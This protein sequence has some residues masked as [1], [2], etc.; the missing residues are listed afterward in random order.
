MSLGQPDMA[1]P[2]P[3]QAAQYMRDLF[4][5]M[6]EPYAE[7]A[8]LSVL[9]GRKVAGRLV[10]AGRTVDNA[11][12]FARSSLVGQLGTITWRPSREGAS[13][14]VWGWTLHGL[15]TG[16][17]PRHG[18]RPT[19]LE[20]DQ[21]MAAAL[22]S[23]GWACMLTPVEF[24]EKWEG[25]D[26]VEQ[27]I[28]HCA[29]HLHHRVWLVV[30]SAETH[31]AACVRL[32]QTA[33]ARRRTSGAYE[34]PNNEGQPCFLHILNASAPVEQFARGTFHLAIVDCMP[35][36]RVVAEIQARSRVVPGEL[37]WL[38]GEPSWLDEPFPTSGSFR[39]T[40]RGAG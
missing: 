14:K 37:R 38:A 15:A 12:Y 4:E 19:L 30:G 36:A 16:S 22:Q 29:T 27:A 3:E 7:M 17:V 23:H 32:D 18:E 5:L 35:S 39:S 1:P 31:R 13:G 21:Y 40:I 8:L 34:F 10:P 6:G 11:P 28:R 33:S 26:A 24:F 20:A 9:E 25:G 2:T